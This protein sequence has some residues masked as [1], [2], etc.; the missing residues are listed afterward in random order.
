MKFN[1]TTHSIILVTCVVIIGGCGIANRTQ[2]EIVIN[3]RVAS[4]PISDIFLKRSSPRA[5]SGESITQDQ[6]MT[7]L[8]AARWAPSSYNEQ[9]WRFIYAHRQTPEWQQLFDLLVP[10]NQGWVKNAAALV[11]FVSCKNFEKNK[12]YSPTHSFDTGAAWMSFSL[13]GSLQGLVVHGM[14]G[15]DFD[16]ARK[17]LKIPDDYDIEAMCAIGKP[18]SADALPEALREG[19]KPSQRKPLAELV[20]HGTFGNK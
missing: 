17:E 6:L 16:K 15:F 18:T 20:F 3:E 12:K 11:L 7:L 13:Q 5:M 9:P 2:K 4:Y 14:S 1:V 8:E 19:E 10:F